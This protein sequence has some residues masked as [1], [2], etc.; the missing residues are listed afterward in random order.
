VIEM[1][2]TER[3]ERIVSYAR[4]YPINTGVG[5]ISVSIAIIIILVVYLSGG[6]AAEPR[7]YTWCDS[8]SV[9]GGQTVANRIYESYSGDI[10]VVPA[11]RTC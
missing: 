1:K 8:P 4:K 10:T 3:R 9:Q 5:V 11:D 2:W 6:F 7:Y